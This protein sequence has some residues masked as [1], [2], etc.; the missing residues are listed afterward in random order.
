MGCYI[1]MHV[2]LERKYYYRCTWAIGY[3]ALMFPISLCPN[4]H[5]DSRGPFSDLTCALS[6]YPCTLKSYLISPPH[7]LANSIMYVTYS[8]FTWG[9]F[10]NG[11]ILWQWVTERTTIWTNLMNLSPS[12]F[13]IHRVQLCTFIIHNVPPSNYRHRR[14]VPFAHIALSTALNAQF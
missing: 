10:I 11:Y 5:S 1:Y 14:F 13:N 12:T 8:R 4:M 2:C 9:Y 3:A 7:E 6:V